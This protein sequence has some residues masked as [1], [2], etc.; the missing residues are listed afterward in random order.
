MRR[1]KNKAKK[2]KDDGGKVAVVVRPW[3]GVR[4]DPRSDACGNAEARPDVGAT[5]DT[6]G[7]MG[8]KCNASMSDCTE[9]PALGSVK[10]ATVRQSDQ[11]ARP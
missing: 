10:C 5:G 9:P 11:R 7:R 8:L 6:Q 3:R 2:K 1:Q 4:Q